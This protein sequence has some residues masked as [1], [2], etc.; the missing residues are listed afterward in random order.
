[1]IFFRELVN[2]WKALKTV[3]AQRI[4]LIIII[5]I[6]CCS[7]ASIVSEALRKFLVYGEHQINTS[8]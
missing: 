6:I 5:V 2:S 4:V 1:M 7:T 8:Y 3:L